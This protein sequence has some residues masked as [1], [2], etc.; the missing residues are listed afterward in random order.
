MQNTNGDS[1]KDSEVILN[2][3]GYST[4]DASDSINAI[5]LKANLCGTSHLRPVP[6]PNRPYFSTW[7][8]RK[9]GWSVAEHLL[10]MHE[11]KSSPCHCG[12]QS[13]Q[14]DP[15]FLCSE[16]PSTSAA[17]SPSKEAHKPRSA[18]RTMTT[19]GRGKHY[20]NRH[21]L[22]NPP[23]PILAVQ[24]PSFISWGPLHTLETSAFPPLWIKCL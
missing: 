18:Q 9:P 7:R 19:K 2:Q 16:H 24:F 21:P 11:Y 4:K 6:I 12:F 3:W 20:I 10:C 1:T 17:S 8:V 23:H 22:W 15:Q 5:S 13:C 14:C